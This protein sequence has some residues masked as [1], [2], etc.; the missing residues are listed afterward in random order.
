M[1]QVCSAIQHAHQRG[2][3]HR[4]LK[5][6]NVLVT[7]DPAGQP[8]VKVLDFGVAR[9]AERDATDPSN[10]THLTL[11]GHFI[12]TPAYMSPEQMRSSEDL[13]TRSDVYA[14][15]AIL[16]QLL[17]DRLPI[18]TAECSLAEAAR[19]I[20]ENQPTRLGVLR[21]ELRGDIETIVAKALE[22]DP[23]RR[24]QSAAELCRDLQ[25]HLAGEMIDVRRDSLMYLMAKKAVRYRNLFIV[26]AL[27]LLAGIGFGAFARYQQQ[28]ERLAERAAE[29]ARH[30]ADDAAA[31]LAD[32]LCATRIE[33]GRLLGQ[34]NDLAGAEKLLWD[35]WFEH[36]NSMA[37]NWA[38][39]E[40]YWRSQCVRTF[41]ADSAECRTLAI[42]PDD[43]NFATAGS[44]SVIR[45]WSYPDAVNSA[46][47]ETGL[48]SVR[49]ICYLPSGRQI[50]VAGDGGAL[51]IDLATG[52]RRALG[53]MNPSSYSIDCASTGLAVAVGSDDGVIRL[54]DPG[55][56]KIDRVDRIGC[57]ALARVR[58][59][60]SCHHLAA[61]YL[62]G[63]VKL[64]ELHI[65]PGIASVT[66]LSPIEGHPGWTG[67]ALGF[68]ADGTMLV[69]GGSDRIVKL[70]RIS[71]GKLLQQFF[72][73]NGP[74]RALGFSPDG[75]RIVV[76][77]F[78]HT[79]II[80]IAT[81]A[82]TVL[83]DA[84]GYDAKFIG[85][86]IV[87]LAGNDGTCRIWDFDRG[88]TV[89]RST[90]SQVR[91]LSSAVVEQ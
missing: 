68:S 31:R 6:A 55:S 3:I 72:T 51:I 5:P 21:R 76:P 80:N 38:L 27:L 4:D 45:T 13:D 89:L 61:I 71:D 44:E 11:N 29:S 69:T 34:N 42:S 87:L 67:T 79:Q 88:A 7:V 41:R 25:H 74:V 81:G 63:A 19:R 91:E 12:G 2:I 66:P 16:Y 37:A 39:R 53:D 77:G 18:P 14:L 23:Q 10:E 33:E 58:F 1:T 65:K 73:G 90:A 54:F 82:M 47:L 86:G 52:R 24:Y 64:W 30:R 56:G 15:G 84:G 43:R 35:E 17:A 78:W 28:N 75:Q 70:W 46:E 9:Q 22:K 83:G 48:K 62:N 40:L 60:N 85:D 57:F 49:S 8:Q 32:E 20:A 50:A 36:P 26:A 59:D